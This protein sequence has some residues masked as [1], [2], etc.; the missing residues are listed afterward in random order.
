MQANQEWLEKRAMELERNQTRHERW[1][2]RKMQ[3]WCQQKDLLCHP[4]I[5]MHGCIVDFYFPQLNLVVELDG[6]P[7]PRR[8]TPARPPVEK[9]FKCDSLPEPNQSSGV[10]Q[11]I[12]QSL[13]RSRVQTKEALEA[14][15][16]EDFHI[17]TDFIIPSSLLT[18]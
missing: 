7:Y 8:K 9:R 12:L 6:K 17:V 2:N 15:K 4:Q 1:L 10:K 3:R 18:F 14:W 5:A 16:T 13:R 11:H